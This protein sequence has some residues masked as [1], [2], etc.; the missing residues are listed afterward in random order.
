MFQWNLRGLFF[1]LALLVASYS[2]TW[3][4][5]RYAFAFRGVTLSSGAFLIVGQDVSCTQSRWTP[6]LV[7]YPLSRFNILDCF[8]LHPYHFYPILDGDD[9]HPLTLCKRGLNRLYLFVRQ[10]NGLFHTSFYHN[11]QDCQGL[12]VLEMRFCYVFELSLIVFY[13]VSQHMFRLY[14]SARA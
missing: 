10:F 6:T 3:A 14:T 5:P 11:V 8:S 9:L 2:P 13:G 7:C 4:T 1:Y 12:C